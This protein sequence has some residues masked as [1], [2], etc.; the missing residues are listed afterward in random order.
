MGSPD[1]VLWWV[2]RKLV[3]GSFLRSHRQYR[4]SANP[5]PTTT[6]PPSDSMS[7]MDGLLFFTE[8]SFEPAVD[9]LVDRPSTLVTAFYSPPTPVRILRTSGIEGIAST[10]GVVQ[11]IR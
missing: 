2:Q 7:I 5:S 3:V 11:R 10:K 4:Y 9:A 8:C 6:S 1:A